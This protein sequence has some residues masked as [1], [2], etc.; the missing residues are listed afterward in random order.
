MAL[1]GRSNDMRELLWQGLVK[2]KQLDTSTSVLQYGFVMLH[3][4]TGGPVRGD[5]ASHPPHV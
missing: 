4:K 2:P 5:N 1:T 3:R